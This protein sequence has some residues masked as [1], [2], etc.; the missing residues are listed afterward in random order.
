MREVTK[1]YGVYEFSELSEEAKK[2][3]KEW[4]LDDPLKCV[5]FEHTYEMDLVSLFPGSSLKIQYSLNSCQGDGL[6]IYGKLDLN[7]ILRMNRSVVSGNEVILS[8]VGVLSEQEAEIIEKYMNVCGTTVTLPHNHF[9][10]YCVADRLDFADDWAE[11]LEYQG[12]KDIQIDTIRKLEKLISR[13]F[14]DLARKYEEYGYSFFYEV[15]DEEMADA[16]ESNGWEFLE[17]GSFFSE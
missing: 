14:T 15:D 17:D 12:Y 11:E 13:M 6:N 5:E 10:C 9:Y 4:Y 1:T 3:A 8:Y 16:C 2:K 7:D